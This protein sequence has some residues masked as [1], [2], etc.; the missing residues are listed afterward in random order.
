MA[1]GSARDGLCRSP[2]I[3]Q[4]P[5]GKQSPSDWGTTDRTR[6]RALSLSKR[7]GILMERYLGASWASVPSM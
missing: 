2:T 1:L 7:V 4:H 3:A 6:P 5:D